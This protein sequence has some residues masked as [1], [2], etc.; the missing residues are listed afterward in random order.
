MTAEGAATDCDACHAD[1][2][3]G[4]T[5]YLI[6]TGEEIDGSSVARL[7]CATCYGAAT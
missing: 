1:I 3:Y 7:L 6:P 4:E 5:A 2:S